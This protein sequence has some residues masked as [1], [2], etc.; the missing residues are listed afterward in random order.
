MVKISTGLS[1]SVI[2]GVLVAAS[3]LSPAGNAQNTIANARRH[4]TSYL[5]SECT[6]D[7]VE[8]ERIIRLLVAERDQIIALG[9]KYRETVCATRP[10]SSSCSS[11][12]SP[13]TTPPSP[14]TR[15]NPSALRRS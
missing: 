7:P 6:A 3:L 8:R 9:P 1:L 13:G 2:L 14:A 5:D 11:A 4:A 15:Q 12:H 10:P